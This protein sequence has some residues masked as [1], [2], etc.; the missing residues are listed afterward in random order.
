MFGQ[1]LS[2]AP[3]RKFMVVNVFKAFGM[4][5]LKIGFGWMLYQQTQ[6]AGWLG[7]QAM[8]MGVSQIFFMPV[9][10]ALSDRYGRVS[11]KISGTVGVMLIALTTAGL[12]YSGWIEAWHYLAL[13]VLLSFFGAVSLPAEKALLPR[14]TSPDYLANGLA[15]NAISFEITR[16]IA[17]ALAGIILAAWG[18]PTCMT[19]TFLLMIPLVLYFRGL[20]VVYNSVSGPTE[21]IFKTW[22]SGITF[23]RERAH[24]SLQFALL[25]IAGMLMAVSHMMPAIASERFG[26]NPAAYGQM[27]SSFGAGAC[28]GAVWLASLNNQNLRP[29]RAVPA[30][31]VMILLVWGLTLSSTLS[32]LLVLMCGYGY[33]FMYSVLRLETTLSLEAGEVHRGRVVSLTFLALS[34]PISLCSLLSGVMAGHLGLNGALR[35]IC[36]AALIGL[37]LISIIIVKLK[38]E[39]HYAETH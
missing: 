7:L 4:Q 30:L 31:F 39:K 13:T 3:F 17:P 9:G 38:K 29:F 36:A 34:L 33:C 20:P 14:L 32:V 16:S 28:L 15:I 18:G 2:Q 35:V 26:N 11:L 10:G 6:S 12:V 24:M 21:S 37:T 5:F 19:M 27:M 25:L 1:S 23:I 22:V 8:A